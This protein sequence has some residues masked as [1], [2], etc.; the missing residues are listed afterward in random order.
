MKTKIVNWFVKDTNGDT[1]E[2]KSETE[3]VESVL[4]TFAEDGVNPV[5]EVWGEDKDGNTINLAIHWSAS[6]RKN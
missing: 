5:D 6:L 4:A 2:F 1:R 3:A